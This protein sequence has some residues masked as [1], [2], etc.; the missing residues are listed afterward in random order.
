MALEELDDLLAQNHV[1]VA[2]TFLE[3]A[4]LSRAR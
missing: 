1:A 3:T 4:G 2:T